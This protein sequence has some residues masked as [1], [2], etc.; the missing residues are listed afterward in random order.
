MQETLLTISSYNHFKIYDQ[1]YKVKYLDMTQQSA[2]VD[3]KASSI[4]GC[5]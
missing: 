3:Q 4:P 5:T 1:F 2:L